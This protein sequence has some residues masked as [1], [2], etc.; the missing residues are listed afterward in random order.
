MDRDIEKLKAENIRLLAENE[1]LKRHLSLLEGVPRV[2]NATDTHEV[3]GQNDVNRIHSGSSSKE[4]LALFSKLFAGRTDVYD[5]GYLFKDKD[6]LGYALACVNEWVKP[7]CGKPHIKCKDCGHRELKSLDDKVLMGHIKGTSQKMNDVVA[8]FPLFPDE[9]CRFLAMDFDGDQW[10]KDTLAVVEA[11]AKKS[12]D[13]A[14]ER[15]RSGNGAHLW[16]FFTEPVSASTARRFGFGL[17]TQ[18]LQMRHEISFSSYDR[19]FPN[20]DK[21]PSGGFGN[22]IALP[23]QGRARNEKGTTLFVDARNDFKPWDDQWVFLSGIKRIAP[24]R[25]DEYLKLQNVPDALGYFPTEPNLSTHEPWK[26]KSS[27]PSLEK[28]DFPKHLHLVRAN[29][30]YVPKAGITERA[31]DHLKRLAAFKNPKFFENQRFKLS[32]HNEPCIICGAR[33]SEKYL[34]LP[35]GIEQKVH[36]LLNCVGITYD[37]EDKTEAGGKIDVTFKGELR[38]NQI[39]PTQIM[40]QDT[41]GVLAALPGSGKTVMGVWLIAQRKVN[42]LILVNKIDLMNQWKAALES[43][44][45]INEQLPEEP[46]GRKRRRN[47]SIIGTLGGGKKTR[48][49]IIDVA[50]VGSLIDET[51]EVKDFVKDYGMILADECHRSGSAQYE[52]VLRQ[53]NARYVYGFSATPKRQDG[54][55]TLVFQQCGSVRYQQNSKKSAEESGLTHTLIPR[56]TQFRMTHSI[57]ASCKDGARGSTETKST[58]SQGEDTKNIG[59]KEAQLLTP[60]SSASSR[61]DINACYHALAKDM[62]RNKLIL[63]DI[64]SAIEAGRTPLILTKYVKHGKTL[65]KQLEALCPQAQVFYLSG[66]GGAKQREA[67][68]NEVRAIE[69]TTPLI[70][71]ATGSLVG[72]GFD[73]ARLDTL[74]ITT[75]ISWEGT[76]TQY[77]DRIHRLYRGKEEVIVYDYV[78]ANERMLVNMYNKRL[79]TYKSLGYSLRTSLRQENVEPGLIFGHTDFFAAFSN[80]LLN[81]TEEIVIA[82]PYVKEKRASKIIELCKQAMCNGVQVIFVVSCQEESEKGKATTVDLRKETQKAGIRLIEVEEMTQHSAIIDRKI[83]WYGNISPLAFPRKEENMMRLDNDGVAARLLTSFT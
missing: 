53:A 78:D 21:M 54:K 83:A 33:E 80:D 7:I 3:S 9:T 11:A 81:A 72:E 25:I 16:F 8:V 66:A 79:K 20:Q 73:V 62:L 61:Q 31:L 44:L 5:H 60:R 37:V 42:T 77:T 19:L 2:Q 49:G 52:T 65:A 23:L 30:I 40:M 59:E 57:G 22:A 34:Y 24:N 35:R 29:G 75:P 71:V 51:G 15:S 64:V 68:L 56:F 76:I 45:D 28:D 26:K 14:V 27:A 17:I 63:D 1:Q 12:F 32:T 36:T 47:Q 74:F 82:S 6:K 48:H 58:T 10:K 55:E 4:K 69:A 67:Q 39:K 18:A 13:I 50:C 43:F 70:L 41:T 46:D 38:G